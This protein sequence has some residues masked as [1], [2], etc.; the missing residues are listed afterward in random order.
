MPK[1]NHVEIGASYKTIELTSSVPGEQDTTLTWNHFVQLQGET[2]QEKAADAARLRKMLA[3][4]EKKSSVSR[5][6]ANEGLLRDIANELDEHG[7]LIEPESPP[8]TQ[9]FID[10]LLEPV[11]KKWEQNIQAEKE[12]E[13]TLGYHNAKH[14]LDVINRTAHLI[15]EYNTY[16][17]GTPLSEATAEALLLAAEMHDYEHNG[18]PQRYS[19]GDNMSYEQNAALAADN[20]AQERGM[21]TYHRFMIARTIMST[22]FWEHSTKPDIKPQTAAEMLMQL[23]DIGGY[24]YN[25]DRDNWNATHHPEKTFGETENNVAWLIDAFNVAEE[26]VTAGAWGN[27]GSE[28]EWLAGTGEMTPAGFP[29]YGQYGFL[30]YL[31]MQ[32]NL[33]AETALPH[34]VSEEMDERNQ[35]IVDPSWEWEQR[36]REKRTMLDELKR[37]FKDGESDTLL[38]DKYREEIAVIKQRYEEIYTRAE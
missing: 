16:T 21:S 14:T 23:G 3:W 8:A 32:H 9:D 5:Y 26:N 27:R 1:E 7:E 28:L 36:L 20:I 18:G 2:E 6:I 10:S 30:L 33:F 29:D 11:R 35:R 24:T 17:E 34:L 4:A 15:I 31:R 25:V 13:S 38:A 22:S 12:L 37:Y 19:K